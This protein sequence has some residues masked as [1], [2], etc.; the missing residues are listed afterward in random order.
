YRV[1]RVFARSVVNDHVCW[2]R[3]GSWK[4][5]EYSR[6]RRASASDLYLLFSLISGLNTSSP[7]C[8]GGRYVS[9]VS[10][11][12]AST[13]KRPATSDGN[14]CHHA[15]R[16][17]PLEGMDGTGRLSR[18]EGYHV[19]SVCRAKM[20]AGVYAEVLQ[21]VPGV[22]RTSKGTRKRMHSSFR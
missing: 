16:D 12:V 14:P 11:I 20:R 22:S 21:S 6:S 5:S 2:A 3:A 18:V 4:P 17:P 19:D 1:S 8:S 9:S 13:I 10:C 15:I 7:H